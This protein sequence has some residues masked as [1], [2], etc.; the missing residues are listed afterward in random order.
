MKKI[1]SLLSLVVVLSLFA[2]CQEKIKTCHGKVKR[3]TDT[4]IVA[5]VDKYEIL[6]DTRDA[7]FLNGAVLFGDSAVFNYIG[8][9]RKKEVRAM[10]VN[11]IPPKPHYIKKGYDSTQELKTAPMS[12]GQKEQLDAFV[13]EAKK[14][15]H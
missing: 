15:G 10:V 13:K 11:W 4:T 9:L 7:N 12:E 5:T 14:H 2:S 1:L 3:V 6:F 8:D